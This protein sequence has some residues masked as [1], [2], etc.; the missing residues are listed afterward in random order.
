ML[1]RFDLNVIRIWK[2]FCYIENFGYKD[3]WSMYLVFFIFR[4]GKILEYK[5]FRLFGEFD[6]IIK[7]VMGLGWGIDDLSKFVFT[8][9]VYC[10][11]SKGIEL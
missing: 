2:F 11:S 3:I 8:L 4:V 7:L 5:N 9:F 6:Q 10:R 1:M